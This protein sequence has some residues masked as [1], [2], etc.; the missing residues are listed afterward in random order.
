M[1]EFESEPEFPPESRMLEFSCPCGAFESWWTF[2]RRGLV[3][4]LLLS[5]GVERK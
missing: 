4:A 1:L 5:G 2:K 3:R